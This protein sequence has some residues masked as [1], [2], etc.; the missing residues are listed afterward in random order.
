MFET[1]TDNNNNK[2]KTP[3]K[4]LHPDDQ[5]ITQIPPSLLIKGTS[6]LKN[7]SCS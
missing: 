5:L 1:E 3:A 6:W 2:N 7:N 4:K